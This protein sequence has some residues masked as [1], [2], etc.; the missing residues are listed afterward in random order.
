METQCSQYS[1][2]SSCSQS[3]YSARI[4]QQMSRE[5]QQVP[6]DGGS[7]CGTGDSEEMQTTSSDFDALLQLEDG[8]YKIEQG[9]QCKNEI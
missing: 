7:S 4:F 9:S 1:D 5:D 2:T 8:S 3:L 6:T